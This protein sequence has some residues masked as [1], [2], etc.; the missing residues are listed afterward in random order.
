MQ[1]LIKRR[2]SRRT[3]Q[4]LANSTMP[5]VV[6]IAVLLSGMPICECSRLRND[7]TRCCTSFGS[8]ICSDCHCSTNTPEGFSPPTKT[9][10][11][12]CYETELPLAEPQSSGRQFA[13]TPP[14]AEFATK[15]I[16][17]GVCSDRKRRPVFCSFD[18]SS[19]RCAWLC[20]FLI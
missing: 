13:R 15:T 20:R 5:F 4:G 1:R 9:P 6:L 19:G 14:V 7:T 8:A 11:S 10:C 2:F 16:E 18:S 12:C 17:V 3:I